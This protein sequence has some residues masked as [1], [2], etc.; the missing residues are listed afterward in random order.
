MLETLMYLGFLGVFVVGLIKLI[1]GIMGRAMA[2]KNVTEFVLMTQNI[3]DRFSGAGSYENIDIEK[4]IDDKI[5]PQIM[6]NGEDK[7]RT[8]SGNDVLLS[9]T[10]DYQFLIVEVK[11]L[12]KSNCIEFLKLHWS[13]DNSVNVINVT[14][15]NEGNFGF[16]YGDDDNDYGEIPINP[17][18]AANMC[19][20]DS[21]DIKW[22]LI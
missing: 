22:T 16:S 10:D 19:D 9:T 11:G 2:T 5:I 13:K 6:I 21:T 3:H 1:S 18:D 15:E 8:R 12:N 14:I 17:A 4:L 20:T 7:I